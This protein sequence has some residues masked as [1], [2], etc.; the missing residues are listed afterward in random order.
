MLCSSRSTL[1]VTC[2]STDYA[3][4]EYHMLV[5]NRHKYKLAL[6][7]M[8]FCSLSAMKRVLED[9]QKTNSQLSHWQRKLSA[10]KAQYEL[11]VKNINEG[12]EYGLP[13]MR[14]VVEMCESIYK[15]EV[16]KVS[17]EITDPAVLEIRKDIRVHFSDQLGVIGMAL[18]YT[19]N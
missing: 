9:W 13:R 4:S 5:Y 15:H 2:P 1:R 10:L 19:Q 6:S 14:D 12:M 3:K 11:D 7:I 17:I 8:L 16:A 18:S